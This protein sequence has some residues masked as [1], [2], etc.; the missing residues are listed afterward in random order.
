MVAEWPQSDPQLLFPSWWPF[1]CHRDC[2]TL[3]NSMQTNGHTEVSDHFHNLLRLQ[4]CYLCVQL[5][6]S[7]KVVG[8][9]AQVVANHNAAED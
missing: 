5:V 3:T 2:T 9:W 4:G 8:K 6:L 7:Y 1:W